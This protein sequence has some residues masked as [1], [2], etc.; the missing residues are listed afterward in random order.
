M[1]RSMYSAISGMNAFQTELDVVGNN[2]A[3]VD[4][5]GYKASRT[6][7]SDILSQTI[8]G[9]SQPSNAGL[10]GTNPQQVGLGVNVASIYTPFTQ[11]ADQETGV[12]T[13]VAL[14]GDGYFMVSPSATTN[15][16]TAADTA[17]TVT[18][19]GAN[20]VYF[21]RAGDFS[22]DASGD[23]V[24]PDG[25]KLLGYL[26]GSGSAP[27]NVQDLG[28]VN[29]GVVPSTGGQPVPGN[30]TF[31]AN[32]TITVTD[33]TTN[34]TVETWVVPL[35]KFFNPSGLSKI[36]NNQFQQTPDSG[37]FGASA[38]AAN[39]GASMGQA[40]S[41]GF[42]TFRVGALEASNVNLTDEFTNM[43]VAQQ[44]FD[45]NSKVINTDNNILSTVLTLEQ[46]A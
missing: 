35:A 43:I 19:V 38:A 14:D 2:I 16:P 29:V 12:N 36:G 9:A 3:N 26:Q 22:V 13:D 34:Q 1:L 10:G 39:A 33:P 23:I 15:T 17:P 25:S 11:G 6:E 18:T 24:T 44:A 27:T 40:G 5:T 42:A 46:Q 37:Q 7:F 30:F 32:G 41:N 4:T 8:A 31:N 28:A 21:T 45:A 20:P